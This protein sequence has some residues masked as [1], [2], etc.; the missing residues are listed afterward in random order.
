V[1][2]N[3]RIKLM[4][5][6]I[7]CMTVF[8]A[9]GCANSGEST[10][11]SDKTANETKDNTEKAD[12]PTA[13]PVKPVEDAFSADTASSSVSSLA[14]EQ[15]KKS[16]GVIGEQ[17][18]ELRFYS[19]GTYEF[20]DDN[21]FSNYDI[22]LKIKSP[23][24]SKVYYTLDGREPDENSILYGDSILFETR[25][26][27]FP[28]AYSFRAVMVDKNGNISDVATRTYLV[29]RGLDKRFSTHVIFITGDPDDLTEEPNGIL[30]G[31]NAFERGRSS[32]RM[33]YIECFE[34]DGTPVFEQYG[35]VRVY[36]GYSRNAT[37]KSL[38]IFAR[39][40]YDEDHKNFKFDAFETPKLYEVEEGKSKVITKY[41]KLVLRNS[42]N[43]N[44][45]SYI[46]DELS[47]RLCKKAGFETY[48]AILP[49]VVY[50]NGSYYSLL[51][52]HESYCDKYFMERFGEAPGEFIVAEGADQKKDDDEDIQNYINEYN[53]MYET[54]I[55]SDL[56]NDSVYNRLN[57]FID[58]ENYLDFFA[59]N[60][61]LNNWDWPNNNFKCFKY[62]PAEGESVG[63]GVYDGRWRYLPHD[64]DY[65]Y[66]LYDQ[67]KTKENYNTL[68][69]VMDENNVRYSPLFTA[70]MERSDCRN[71]F[72]AKTIEFV[73]GALS[74]ASIK[75]EY[76][77]LNAERA[78]ELKY[79][80]D[81]LQIMKR[82]GYWDIWSEASH[83][84]GYEQQIY[85]FAEK[86]A[87]YVLRYMDDLLPEM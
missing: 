58:V 23:E 47:Q 84:S 43:D 54:F 26:G 17:E 45:F 16:D 4:F 67:I 68:R 5:L 18:A 35:G 9:A 30:Y 14:V 62:V 64:M 6:L 2:K 22:R 44:Q 82:K 56:T 42:G 80:Y 50:L 86:R 25:G 83:Y 53:S 27:D 38:K 51:W 12:A 29:G 41:D 46:R 59:W 40:M 70:L 55:N 69:V 75:E 32:E 85:T 77:K 21:M 57:E 3:K 63:E 61:A 19:D 10:E 39:K 52:L 72:R 76:E 73:N 11:K 24:G 48:E 81:F 66:G 13:S 49:V 20:K 71:Y 7:L 87:A 74:E 65:T 36:G 60:I 15:N 1:K 34:A 8:F 33:V 79:Y 28:D 31:D 37:I 78:E